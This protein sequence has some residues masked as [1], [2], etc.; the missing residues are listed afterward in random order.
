MECGTHLICNLSVYVA[1]CRRRKITLQ[2]RRLPFFLISPDR[3]REEQYSE[4]DTFA[5][6]RWVTGPC[7]AGLSCTQPPHGYHHGSESCP[8]SPS[9]G[10]RLQG[11]Q[12]PGSPSLASAAEFHPRRLARRCPALQQGPPQRHHPIAPMSI[13][14]SP[15]MMIIQRLSSPS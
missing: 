2:K 15:H 8:D 11:R 6:C 1:S 4:T 9:T 12:P 3:E 13:T 10:A 14:A 5:G 7:R